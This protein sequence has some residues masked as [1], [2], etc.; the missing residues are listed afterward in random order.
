M[1]L[2]GNF[3]ALFVILTAITLY[4]KIKPL[5][6]YPEKP[7]VEDIWWGPGDASKVDTSIKP[8]KINIPDNVSFYSTYVKVLFP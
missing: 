7:Q 6:N 2:V 4:S 5:V 8:F 1:G 3:A